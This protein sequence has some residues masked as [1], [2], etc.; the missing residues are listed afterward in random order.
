MAA[1]RRYSVL[2][3][4]IRDVL[5]QASGPLRADELWAQAQQCHAGLGLATVYRMLRQLMDDGEVR[6]VTLPTGVLYEH[7]SSPEHPH[8]FCRQC[9]ATYDLPSDL[10]QPRAFDL[11]F[12]VEAYQLTLLGVCPPCLSLQEQAHSSP[13]RTTP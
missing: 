13:E 8:F 7:R 11:P 5:K 9:K 4:G 6:Q 1:E 12:R 10:F 3:E 2:R